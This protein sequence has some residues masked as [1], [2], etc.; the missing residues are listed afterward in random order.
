M[1]TAVLQNPIFTFSKMYINYVQVQF[2]ELQVRCLLHTPIF[3]KVGQALSG[4]VLL[5]SNRR[6]LMNSGFECSGE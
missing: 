4:K 6:Y 2:S 1:R 3:V 5:I